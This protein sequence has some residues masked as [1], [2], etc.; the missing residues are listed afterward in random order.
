VDCLESIFTRRSVRR[1]SSEAVPD[2][3]VEELLR[4][5]MAAPSAGNEQPWRFVAVTDRDVLSRL[6]SVSPYAS[7]LLSAPLAIVVYGDTRV[8]RFSGYWVQ[9]CS[10]ATQN[11]LLAANALGLGGVWLGMHPEREREDGIREICGGEEGMVPFCIVAVGRPED[12]VPVQ[13]RYDPM[14]VR[15]ERWE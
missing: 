11:L 15:R 13:D 4:A 12:T 9:D 7:S 5:A 14:Y 1:F 10:A 2:A 6:A 8:Q 3:M